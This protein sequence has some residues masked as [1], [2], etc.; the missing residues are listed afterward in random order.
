MLC[1]AESE[2]HS[3]ASIISMVHKSV[4]DQFPAIVLLE[5]IAEETAWLLEPIRQ[6]Q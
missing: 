1:P 6:S 3:G 4:T 2:L 5:I